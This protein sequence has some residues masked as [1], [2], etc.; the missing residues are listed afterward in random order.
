LLSFV[1]EALKFLDLSFESQISIVIL[2]LATVIGI[3][4]NIYVL[5]TVSKTDMK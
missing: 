2:S 5:V 1:I 4:A 3:T